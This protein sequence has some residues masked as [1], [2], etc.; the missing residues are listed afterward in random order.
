MSP[1]RSTFHSGRR[2]WLPY[3]PPNTVAA[4][5]GVLVILAFIAQLAWLF[6]ANAAL[7]EVDQYFVNRCFAAGS[8]DCYSYVAIAATFTWV[9][10]CIW[11]LSALGGLLFGLAT[12]RYPRHSFDRRDMGLMFR[13]V[14]IWLAVVSLIVGI[15]LLVLC[16]TD[17]FMP[18]PWGGNNLPPSVIASARE[19]T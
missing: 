9:S 11:T 1:T 6:N 4:A 19:V 7:W 12:L 2:S 16:K 10:L 17:A 14:A 15:G 18:E 8:R 5:I 3:L 13:P